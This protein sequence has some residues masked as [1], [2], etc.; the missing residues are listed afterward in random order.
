MEGELG[1]YLNSL[2]RY[3]V[4]HFS[5]TNGITYGFVLQHAIKENYG[6]HEEI[7]LLKRLGGCLF[8]Q[9]LPGRCILDFIFKMGY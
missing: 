6:D 2:Y 1:F 9:R 8:K 5:N 4:I 3:D 7:Y